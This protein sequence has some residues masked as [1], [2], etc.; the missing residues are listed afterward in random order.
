MGLKDAAVVAAAAA[1]AATATASA[2]DS[3]LRDT[4]GGGDCRLWAPHAPP[5]PSTPTLAAEP[6]STRPSVARNLSRRIS[7]FSW[8]ERKEEEE[9]AYVSR[10][11]ENRAE[12][13]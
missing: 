4:R 6:H 3:S 10:G 5:T 13:E 7:A 11:S 2:A 9:D 8:K 12:R 1:A